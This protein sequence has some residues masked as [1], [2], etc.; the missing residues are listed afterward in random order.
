MLTS[1]ISE[2]LSRDPEWDGH[3]YFTY[4]VLPEGYPP[5]QMEAKFPEFIK[6]HYGPE[7]LREMGIS[8][9]EYYAR[10]ENYYGYWLQP[11]RQI[12]LLPGVGD[13]FHSS[14]IIE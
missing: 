6:K 2:P 8:F 13:N 12:Y 14:D 9:D 7:F 3:C 5:A 4:I 1:L 10:Q 11:L